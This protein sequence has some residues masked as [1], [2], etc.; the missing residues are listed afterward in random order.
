MCSNILVFRLVGDKLQVYDESEFGSNPIIAASARGHLSAVVFLLSSGGAVNQVDLEKRGA[1][2]HAGN[3]L[4][5]CIH[6]GCAV[7]LAFFLLL[8]AAPCCS[9]PLPLLAETPVSQLLGGTLRLCRFFVSV[10]IIYNLLV[11]VAGIL[12]FFSRTSQALLSYN[13]RV[14]CQDV[15]GNTPLHYAAENGDEDVIDLLLSVGCETALENK[16]GKTPLQILP[17]FPW[18]EAIERGTSDPPPVSA[19]N[20]VASEVCSGVL[21]DDRYRMPIKPTVRFC[22]TLAVQ[23]NSHAAHIIWESEPHARGE[24]VMFEACAIMMDC[25]IPEFKLAL[26]RQSALQVEQAH[27]IKALRI[28]KSGLKDFIKSAEKM[29]RD[30]EEKITA[31]KKDFTLKQELVRLKAQNLEAV[32][33]RK[34]EANEQAALLNAV[35]SAQ[36]PGVSNGA[37]LP[38]SSHQF[39]DKKIFL[40]TETNVQMQGLVPGSTFAFPLPGPL[41]PLGDN[42]I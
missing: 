16:Q 40:T 19:T 42:K 13:S 2:H 35:I 6:V 31:C 8:C 21:R 17:D 26:E 29:D 11:F 15:L 38:P 24:R 33:K 25:D 23:V 7:W 5:F 20:V 1:L 27:S 36:P 37:V 22:F 12:I 14:N 10:L 9:V 30:F 34:S 4:Y 32:A 3:F 28:L 18:K 41:S 39:W